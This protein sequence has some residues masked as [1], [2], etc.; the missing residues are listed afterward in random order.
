MAKL[1]LEIEDKKLKF[2]KDLINNLSFVKI[3]QTE[4]AEDSDE[5]V[6]ENLRAA[7]V[8]LKEVLEGKKKSRPAREFLNEL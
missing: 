7:A 8:E 6:R 5:D 3:D 4:F 1:T 2:F